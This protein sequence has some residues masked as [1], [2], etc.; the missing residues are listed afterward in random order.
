MSISAISSATAPNFKGKM[1]TTDNGTEYYKTNNGLK[2]G[3]T[4]G[5]IGVLA[6]F[7]PYTDT[8]KIGALIGLGVHSGIGAYIDYKRNQHAAEAA[9]YIRKVGV[10]NAVLTRE[11]IELNDNNKPYYK[12][13]DG[14]KYG[15]IIGAAMGA[16]IGLF[17]TAMMATIGMSGLKRGKDKLA[18][19]GSSVLLF[20]LSTGLM[21]LGGFIMGKITDYFTNRA[22]RKH[23]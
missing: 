23:A 21:A 6:S 12:S 22:A 10:K 9:D 15:T 20:A 5:G 14:G 2:V 18:V 16:I 13:K 17:P 4:Y 11:D 7:M 8:G 1:V 19:A 3:A